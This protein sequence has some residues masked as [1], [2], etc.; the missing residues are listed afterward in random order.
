MTRI[1]TQLQEAQVALKESS[2]AFGEAIAA[3]AR[4]NE[5]QSRVIDAVIAATNE[6]LS[7]VRG[8]EH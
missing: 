4:A 8:R 3:L 5:A 6:G 7:Q 2:D 1:L